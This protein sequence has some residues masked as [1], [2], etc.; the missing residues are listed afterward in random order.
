MRV[1]SRVRRSI[2]VHSVAFLAV[3]VTAAGAVA[4]GPNDDIIRNL[5]RLDDLLPEIPSARQD[6]TL[7]EV[8]IQYMWIGDS[9]T[10]KARANSIR[11]EH[12]RAFAIAQIVRQMVAQN[13]R[14]DAVAC[15]RAH[16][17]DPYLLLDVVSLLAESNRGAS[18]ASLA[19]DLIAEPHLRAVALLSAAAAERM[20]GH[21]DSAT[22]ITAAIDHADLERARRARNVAA[23]IA[24]A[25]GVLGD[26]RLMLEACGTFP[27]TSTGRDKLS[28]IAGQLASNGN[29]AMASEVAGLVGANDRAGILSEIATELSRKG[30]VPGLEALRRSSVM[31]DS[32]R[33]SVALATVLAHLDGGN[34]AEGI[35]VL[36]SLSDSQLRVDAEAALARHLLARSRH[37]EAISVLRGAIDRTDSIEDIPQRVERR[38]RLAKTLSQAGDPLRA[39][40]LVNRAREYFASDIE[41]I[42][43]TFDTG[44]VEA[45]VGAEV[46]TGNPSRAADLLTNVMR[47]D[48]NGAWLRISIGGLVALG[49]I[50]KAESCAVNADGFPDLVPE[51]I[52]AVAARIDCP[53]ELSV[54]EAEA[55]PSR[56]ADFLAAWGCGLLQRSGRPCHSVWA[57]FSSKK[58]AI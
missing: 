19:R 43:D 47:P 14:D 22:E 50:K 8:A 6:Y 46:T 48:Y 11:D 39:A 42:I 54:I 31:T 32:A 10:A 45:M 56:K 35:G 29:V 4:K 23:R 33:D 36:E 1:H 21:A 44:L 26:Q 57:E 49:E 38:M 28:R 18:A 5:K 7:G 55:D 12:M 25:A 13:R 2:I 34:L 9:T 52:E 20:A 58:G 24:V 51:F 17:S 27:D 37:Q 53:K 3:I 41:K 16:I 15:A 30:N 40:K